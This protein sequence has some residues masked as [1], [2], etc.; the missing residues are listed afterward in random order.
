MSWGS[1]CSVS[2]CEVLIIGETKWKEKY[3]SLHLY[4]K[5]LVDL[6]LKIYSSSQVVDLKIKEIYL[7]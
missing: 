1:L 6:F 3:F 5:I 2:M 7:F 4:Y